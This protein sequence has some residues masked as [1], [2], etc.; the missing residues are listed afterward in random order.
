[1]SDS[2]TEIPHHTGWF[3]S[4]SDLPGISSLDSTIEL[5]VNVCSPSADQ[6]IHEP[7]NA[8]ITF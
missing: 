5:G 1:M 4:E 2:D 7:W 3:G 8:G 6:T